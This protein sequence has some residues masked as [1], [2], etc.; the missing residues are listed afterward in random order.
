MQEI[1]GIL[2]N[3]IIGIQLNTNKNVP[4]FIFGVYMPYDNNIDEFRTELDTVESLYLYYS[5]YGKVFIA[6]DFNSSL[7]DDNNVNMVKSRMLLRFAHDNNIAIPGTDFNV[8][9]EQYSFIL[10]QS[11]LDYILFDKSCVNDLGFYMI[12][13]EGSVSIT[14]DHLPV[15][16]QIYFDCTRHHLLT[17][18]IKSPAW[19]KATSCRFRAIPCMRKYSSASARFMRNAVSFRH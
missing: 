10:K 16:A 8:E 5:N 2:S 6:G 15:L 17:S 18:G 1:E 9:G 12:T 4:V 11:T 14:S 19:H 13:K 3:R 7:I